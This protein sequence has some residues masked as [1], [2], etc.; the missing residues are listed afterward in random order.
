MKDIIDIKRNKNKTFI[1]KK[2]NFDIS[3]KIDDN[4]KTR[5]HPSCIFFSK[6]KKKKE[7]KNLEF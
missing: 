3:P 1:E 5:K 7:K 2:I 6:L 4:N